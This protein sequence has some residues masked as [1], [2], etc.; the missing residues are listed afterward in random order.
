[1]VSCGSLRNSAVNNPNKP[2]SSIIFQTLGSCDPLGL[3]AGEIP[4]NNEDRE[5][6]LGWQCSGVRWSRTRKQRWAE[7][8][9]AG[10]K[11]RGSSSP[12]TMASKSWMTWNLLGVPCKNTS[13]LPI[14]ET[15]YLVAHRSLYLKKLCRGFWRVSRFGNCWGSDAPPG[16]SIWK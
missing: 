1:M 15:T 14:T 10:R 8:T 13:S 6:K 7:L 11:W 5:T 12:G 3:G 4:I 16:L 9:V 2:V